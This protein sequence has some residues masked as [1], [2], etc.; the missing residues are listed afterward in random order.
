MLRI[1]VV[2]LLLCVLPASTTAGFWPDLLRINPEIP[3][4][5]E[6]FDGLVTI[7]G[8]IPPCFF[9]EVNSQGLAHDTT[10]EGNTLVFDVVLDLRSDFCIF[11]TFD[12]ALPG[13]PSGDY[14]LVLNRV[15]PSVVFPA[16]ESD[17]Q[18]LATLSFSVAP[19][20]VGVQTLSEIPLLLLVLATLYL[21]LTSAQRR[22]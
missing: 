2:I 16:I 14:T 13:L 21:G 20:A 17:R 3:T 19:Q 18:E 12:Y 22:N 11:G 9:P 15:T 7:P 10:L 1:N 4:A 5:N 8:S 6:P